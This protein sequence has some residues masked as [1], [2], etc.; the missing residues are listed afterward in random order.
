[1]KLWL[2]VEEEGQHKGLKTLFVGSPD[3]TFE[4]IK[5]AIKKHSK[6]KIDQIYFGAGCCTQI[7][8]EVLNECIEKIVKTIEITIEVN[9][10]NE[11]LFTDAKYMYVNK[12]I[13]INDKRLLNLKKIKDTFNYCLKIQSVDTKD[14]I[15]LMTDL[16]NFEETNCDNLNGKKYKEDKVVK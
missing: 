7:N 11:N 16:G 9:I 10:N 14:K 3:I 12:V 8:K 6:N 5:D 15:L 1:M 13:T 4:E 2:G